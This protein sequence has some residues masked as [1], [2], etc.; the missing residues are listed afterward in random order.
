MQASSDLCVDFPGQHHC[1]RR[2]KLPAWYWMVTLRKSFKKSCLDVWNLK[3]LRPSFRQFRNHI[4][5]MH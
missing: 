4:F 1:P 5:R 3:S 2:F